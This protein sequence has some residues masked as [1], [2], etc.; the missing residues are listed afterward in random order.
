[1]QEPV[2]SIGEQLSDQ[3]LERIK[4]QNTPEA[5]SQRLA[6]QVAENQ[7]REAAEQERQAQMTAAQ[8]ARAEA[9]ARKEQSDAAREHAGDPEN[10]R[11]VE[12][13]LFYTDP[14]GR[15]FY[16]NDQGQKI[17]VKGKI[18]QVDDRAALEAAF[19][20]PMRKSS[21]IRE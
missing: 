20:K 18:P 13:K 15:N 21:A 1:M 12:G 19:R 9:R 11:Y 5:V 7:K 3:A 8:R 14:N 4:E 2:K 6:Q 17:P 16:V 10:Y